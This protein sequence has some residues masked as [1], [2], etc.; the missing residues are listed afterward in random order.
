MVVN[1]WKIDMKEMVTDGITGWLG[2]IMKATLS[3]WFGEETMESEL[4]WSPFM[5]RRG[6]HNI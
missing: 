4:H 6:F 2:I 1:S 3:Q 5:N